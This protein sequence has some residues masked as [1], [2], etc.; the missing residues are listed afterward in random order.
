MLG[1]HSRARPDANGIVPITSIQTLG[2]NAAC[3]GTTVKVRGIV[4]G[5]DNLYGS[6]YDA[7]YKGDSG[8]WLQ[9]ATRDP[10]ATTSNAIF[11]AGI[12]R[13]ADQPGRP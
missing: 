6:S 2:A 8:I 1:G 13:D 9:E 7:I 12:R 3:N 10:A 5:I 11:V 4:T